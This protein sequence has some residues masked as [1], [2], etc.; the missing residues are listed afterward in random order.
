MQYLQHKFIDETI[1]FPI[2]YSWHICWRSDYCTWMG[3]FLVS[4][5]CFIDLF[6]CLYASVVLFLF[7]WHVIYLK[8]SNLFCWKLLWLR[9]VFWVAYKFWNSLFYSCTNTIGILMEIKSVYHFEYHRH[10]NNINSSNLW[11]R[12]IFPIVSILACYQCFI[13]FSEQVF[14]FLNKSIPIK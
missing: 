4:V 13:A 11:T 12:D 9:G 8:V 1:L 6:I 7:P 2:V 14:T 5:F 10:C 3:L